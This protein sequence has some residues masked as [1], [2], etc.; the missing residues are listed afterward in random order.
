MGVEQ[1]T[2][3]L[4]D[5]EKAARH[6]MRRALEREPYRLVEA[7]DGVEALAL[8]EREE[9][10]LVF[11]DLNMPSVAGLDVLRKLKERPDRPD[12][13]APLVIVVTAHGSERIAVE[14]MKAGAYDYLAKPYD[15]DELRLVAR[16]AVEA[17]SLRQENRRLR[18]ALARTAGQGELVGGESPA[19]KRVFGVIE[20]VA[21]LDVTVHIEGES[22]TGKELVA[23]E[24]HRRS[25]RAARPFVA[26]NCAALPEALVESE[27]FGHERGAFTG[28]TAQR[29]GKFEVARSGSLF[30]DEVGDLPLASQAKLL[31]VLETRR[32][33]R[34]GGSA[35]IEADVRV[36]A[37]TNKDL[38]AAIA[39]G[40][41]REDLYY[42]L[43][44]VDMELPPLRARQG[45]IGVLA[46]HFVEVAATK[47]G[48]AVKGV[49]PEALAALASYPWPGNVREL[50][51]AVEK[52]VILASGERL[53]LDDLPP[54]VAAGAPDDVEAGPEP[55]TE[56]APV[57]GAEAAAE[58]GVTEPVEAEAL[59]PGAAG[60]A[61]ATADAAAGSFADARRRALVR[62]ETAYLARALALHR[63]NVTATAKALGMYRQSL[64]QK[65]RELGLE[66]E[67]YRSGGA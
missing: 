50:L 67:R 28:A 41:F 53:L 1:P 5:D 47:Y 61:T 37:A 15:I 54:E 30:L 32:F 6:G 9:P 11:L 7:E 19:M 66:A 39:A 36:I 43:K 31:R 14:A 38:K 65:L 56:P 21:P 49:A 51:H 12:A 63:G 33:E 25:P 13:A 27:L 57:P 26:V 52:A 34:L 59:A 40:T 10:A 29:K 44:V 35:S 64:Q 60:A 46:R 58:A 42:R 20:K 4:C 55:A 18:T 62:F 17:L 22:G 2:V 45:D 3:L 48:K 8:V 16:R 24:V 23:R